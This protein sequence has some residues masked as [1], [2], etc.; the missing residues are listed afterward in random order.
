MF[1]QVPLEN[2]KL[3][4]CL[5]GGTNIMEQKVIKKWVYRGYGIAFDGAGSWSFGNDY[6]ERM[7]QFLMLIIVHH[8]M[9]ITARIIF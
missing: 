6:T 5:F 4:I 9:L 1:S 2:V 8:L 7:L 3:N